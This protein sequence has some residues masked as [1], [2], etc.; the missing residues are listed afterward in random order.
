VSEVPALRRRTLNDHSVDP[1]GDYV[2]YWM[3]A[4]RRL[5]WNFALDR[6]LERCRELK[7]PLLILEALRCG[8]RY[9]SDRLHKFVL[10]GMADHVRAAKRRGWLRYLP[11]VEPAPG[12]G[13][14]LLAALA[15]R[16][17][18]VVGDDSPA[19]FLPRMLAAAARQV[20]V[21]LEVVDSNGLLPLRAADRVYSRAV[22]L[23]RFLQ[24]TLPEHLEDLPA[25]DPLKGVRL[26]AF[27]ALAPE[28]L[29]RWPACEPSLL[30]GAGLERLPIDHGVPVVGGLRGGSAAGSRRLAEFLDADLASYG[31]ARNHPDRDASSRLSPYMHFGQVATHQIFDEVVAREAWTLD[32]LSP[33]VRGLREGWWGMSPGAESFLDQVVTWRELGF[34]MAWQR[35][36]AR[37]YGS[38]P[39]WA[40]QT[41]AA[42]GA[43]SRPVC[44]SLQELEQARTHDA[45]WNAAQ[46]QLRRE[47][48]IHNYLRMLWGKKVLEW[49]RTPQA[50][51]AVL[52]ELNDKY[53][54]DGRDP[55]STSGILWCLGRYDRAWGPE[56]PIFGK[57]RYMSS[58]STVRKLRLE[59]YL[60]RFG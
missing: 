54:L 31:E 36:D 46:T 23:R 40:Q 9:A 26:P 57:V 37:D 24:R 58:E 47:G 38:L 20:P 13:Q 28:V 17:C 30:G 41:L 48:R 2:L 49:S 53:A 50:A 22:D 21:A 8:H 18:V 4:S 11:Y 14:G 32:R 59:G 52:L 29:R 10:D 34:N 19:F 5:G 3:T 44:Y 55:N 51:L 7:R 42:H 25:A 16:A 35:T 33:K 6:A 15:A 27:P 56:R 45:V 39:G 60:E 43:D 1:D 12:A